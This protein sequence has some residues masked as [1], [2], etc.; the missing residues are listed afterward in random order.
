MRRENN[1]S[2]R[3]LGRRLRPRRLR[4]RPRALGPAPARS[5]RS[6]CPRRGAR[7]RSLR[8]G[9]D[10]P[11]RQRCTAGFIFFNA[12]PSCLSRVTRPTLARA[13]PPGVPVASSSPPQPLLSLGDPPARAGPTLFAWGLRLA[14]G[15]GG[16]ETEVARVKP[17]GSCSL[18][19]FPR[20]RNPRR[21]PWLLSWAAGQ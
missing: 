7:A 11:P 21:F 3:C 12:I 10:C 17:H 20:A 13:S 1:N 15:G 2:P 19:F 8:S 4:P 9:V 5:R 18:S 14:G 16:R 6:E